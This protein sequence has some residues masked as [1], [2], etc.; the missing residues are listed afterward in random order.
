MDNIVAIDSFSCIFILINKT[1][2]EHKGN[3]YMF[4]AVAGNMKNNQK[5]RPF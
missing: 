5:I 2:K 4:A 3:N 1:V